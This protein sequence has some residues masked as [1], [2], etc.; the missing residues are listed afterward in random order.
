MARGITIL[1][2]APVAG[3]AKGTRLGYTNV[4]GVRTALGDDAEFEIVGRTDGT[5]IDAEEA[6]T[7][8]A[9]ATKSVSRMNKDE[10]AAY[11]LAT[12][13]HTFEDGVSN[14]A[15]KLEIARLTDEAEARAEA[16]AAAGGG[17]E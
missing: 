10:L 9:T 14:Q 2:K 4:E 15:M 5:P 16:D 12:F 3:Y 17:D 1:L 6:E 11:A 8:T 7:L 13:D